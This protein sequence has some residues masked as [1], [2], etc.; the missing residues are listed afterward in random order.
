MFWKIGLASI[1]ALALG[2]GLSLAAEGGGCGM[3]NCCMA[4]MKSDQQAARPTALA[5]TQPAFP[6]GQGL[7]LSD[8]PGSDQ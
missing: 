3:G 2:A 5:T 4:E 6:A 7:Y 8:A 1:T